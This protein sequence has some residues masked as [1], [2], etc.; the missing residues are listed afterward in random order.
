[1]KRVIKYASL[2]FVGTAMLVACSKK[3]DDPTPPTTPTCD[4]G[5][6]KTVNVVINAPNTPDYAKSY[7]QNVTKCDGTAKIHLDITSTKD[8]DKIY[9]VRSS[10]NGVPEPVFPGDV[11]NSNGN[12]FTNGSL[13]KGY[14]LDLPDG[15]SSYKAFIIDVPVNVRSSDAAESDVYTIWITNGTGSFAATGKKAEIGPIVVTLKYKTVAS[16]YITATGI[17]LGDQTATPPSYLSTDGIISAISG[18]DIFAGETT[19]EEKKNALNS[20]DINL[21][22]IASDQ[23]AYGTTCGNATGAKPYFI[24]V[25]LRK[26]LGTCLSNTEGTDATVFATY[27][28]KS[29]ES[30]TAADIA[31][32]ATPS[33]DRVEV[34]EG[35]VYVFQTAD[36]RKG[37]IKAYSLTKAATG[38]LAATV[39]VDVKVQATK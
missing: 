26:D 31:A 15:I 23:T 12:T 17:Q 5:S 4:G 20:A 22:S 8:M 13:S 36:G 39:K 38:R 16:T 2:L 37:A 3:E 34:T 18:A 19:D 25:G 30:L 14:S 24:G 11:K 29:F 10:D 7:S 27:T 32:F 9:I 6:V 1:M 35:G 21:V 28:T 33:N